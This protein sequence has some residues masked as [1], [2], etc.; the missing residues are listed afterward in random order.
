MCGPTGSGKTTT[1]YSSLEK[2]NKDHLNIVTIEDPVEYELEGATQI[3]VNTKAGVTYESGLRSIMR[4]DPDVI[5]VGEM[6]DR[7][8]ASW[9]LTA[10]ETGH[11]VFSTLHTR[12]TRGT[13]TRLLDMYPPN[14]QDEVANQ[15]S[16]GLSHIVCQKLIPRAD[17]QGRVVAMEILNN[18]YAVANQIRTRKVEQIYNVL[19]TQTRDITSERMTTLERSLA[20]LVKTGSITAV[21]AEK[22]ANHP[23]V[24]RDELRDAPSSGAGSFPAGSR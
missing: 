7:N 12:D 4:Q 16:L 20:R 24:L 15:L 10:A 13:I 17:G 1:L 8:S 11:L 21:E 19:Q 22:W 5:F 6:R 9:T 23:A 2:I 3:P 18:T 14:Q